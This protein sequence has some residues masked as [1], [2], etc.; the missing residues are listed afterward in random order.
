MKKENDIEKYVQF[1]S[2]KNV[3][4]WKCTTKPPEST[5]REIFHSGDTHPYLDHFPQKELGH[6]LRGSFYKY[7][8][9]MQELCK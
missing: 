3:Y 5:I 1:F 4:A 2:P 6:V 7:Q 9:N 8:K